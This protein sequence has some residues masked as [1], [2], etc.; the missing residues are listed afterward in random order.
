[1]DPPGYLE[2]EHRELDH[3][4][5]EVEYLAERRSVGPAKRRFDH[6][7]ARLLAHLREEE[8]VLFPTFRAETGDPE[9][10][11]K[12]L[13][14]QHAQL[15]MVL[16]AVG[17]AIEQGDYTYFCYGLS[18]LSVLLETHQTTEERLW[19]GAGE[20]SSAATQ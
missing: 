2:T 5:A 14:D 6:F 17:H 18:A 4:L 9:A 16:E 19:P 20:G 12:R 1:M 10:I 13:H 8:D 11:V 7:R 15:E 3:L